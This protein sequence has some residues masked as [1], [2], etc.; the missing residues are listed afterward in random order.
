MLATTQRAAVLRTS[1]ILLQGPVR[2]FTDRAAI[3]RGLPQE[4]LPRNL[5]VR[6]VPQK[7]AWVVERFGKFNRIL[8]PGLRFLIPF[9]DK[10]AY[11]HNLKEEALS[12]T[13]Q[14]AITKDNVT[15]NIDGV[16]YVKILDPERASYGV[17]NLYYA[18]VHKLFLLIHLNIIHIHHYDLSL[19][20]SFIEI[21]RPRCG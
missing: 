1:M 14:T 2:R 9:V 7:S 18:M 19:S 21:A 5:G 15:I 13:G 16:L 20:L 12:V 11:V 4:N 10:I 8:D 6:V 3:G 17:E